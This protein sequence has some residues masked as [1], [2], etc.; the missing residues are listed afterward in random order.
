M[1]TTR[2]AALLTL[3]LFVSTL[4]GCAPSTSA[5]DSDA[6][7]ERISRV[8]NGLLTTTVIAGEGD[9]G[10][11]ITERMRFY[12]VP[13]VSIAV[14]DG[15]EIA[16]ARGYGELEAGSGQPVDTATLFQAASISKPVAAIAALGMVEEGLFSLDD[17]VNSRLTSW[18][19]PDSDLTAEEKVTPR[20]L[21]S[22]SAGTTVH[23]F[24]GYASGTAVPTV[25]QVLD[26]A[27]PSNTAPV[28]VDV[29]PGSLWRYSGGGTSIMQLLLSDVTGRP[30]HEVMAERVLRP[31]QMVHSTY[32][33]PLPEAFAPRAARAH[34]ADG[35]AVEGGWHTY[36]EQ[37][38]AGLWTTPSDLARLFLEVHHALHGASNRILSQETTREMLTTQAGDYGL[39]F[40]LTEENGHRFFQHGGAN[41]GFRALAMAFLDDGSPDQDAGRG[42]F[43]MTNGDNGGSLAWRSSAPSRA[44]RDGT[45]STRT[46][47]RRWRSTGT[48]WR[49]WS[50]GTTSRGGETHP[51]TV[52]L[53]GG[54]LH[55]ALPLYE[56]TRPV[57]AAS[58]ERFFFLE[59]GAELEFEREGE[60]SR[61]S[62]VRVSGIGQPIVA[63][64]AVDGSAT[65]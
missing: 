58:P 34:G 39:G 19:L 12:N 63:E 64:R 56:G 53:D 47:A 23:G 24:P 9:G 2:S 10:L 33:Q 3:L 65:P 17:D 4:G 60:G 27:G 21:L 49:S 61:P 36:P 52:S 37:A 7:E 16:W 46:S 43:I 51:V 57:Y 55:I 20:R 8:E 1:T 40:A 22:H 50:A 26:G 18:Q 54:T 13:G 25:V 29:L 30:F 41:R 44:S 5:A 28:R 59:V 38:A 62:R 35:S 6:H 15:G 48:R 32:E 31:A 14:V 11:A 42:V 45:P